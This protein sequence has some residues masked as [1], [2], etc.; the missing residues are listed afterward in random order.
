VNAGAGSNLEATRR[1]W[2]AFN[3]GDYETLLELIHPEIEWRPAQGPGGPEGTVYRGREGY[4]QWIYDDVIPVWEF[5][6][7]ENLELRELPDGRVLILG[8]LRG[9]GRGSGV[10]VSVPFGQIADVRDGMA[11]RL[12]GYLDHESALEAAGLS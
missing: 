9:K 3:R 4:R 6:R 5:F 10:D 8:H 1:A 12:T 7:G 11:Y 2:D